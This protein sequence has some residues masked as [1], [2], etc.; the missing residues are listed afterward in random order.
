MRNPVPTLVATLATFLLAAPAAHAY[1]APPAGTPLPLTHGDPPQ[2]GQPMTVQIDPAQWEPGA[3]FFFDWVA[4]RDTDGYFC[5]DDFGGS[6][7]ATYTPTEEVAGRS[8]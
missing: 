5:T 7:M 6:G 4:C 1:L 2:V 8:I 3:Y